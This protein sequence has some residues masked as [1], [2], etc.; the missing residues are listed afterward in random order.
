MPS[1]PWY[2]TPASSIAVDAIYSS[3]T[4]SQTAVDI[5]DGAGS[6]FIRFY[7]G[8]GDNHL[9]TQIISP[10]GGNFYNIAIGI[11]PLGV[12]IK[13]AMSWQTGAQAS[14]LNGV[15]GTTAAVAQ[16][17]TGMTT[18]RIGAITGN[19]QMLNG[20]VQRVRYWPRILTNTELQSVTT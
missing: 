3:F 4:E 18:L 16:N 8:P 13:A 9:Y 14:A 17:P 12:R 5:D 7:S 11:V 2:N 1:S 20:W 10:G 15:L 19:A 6:N